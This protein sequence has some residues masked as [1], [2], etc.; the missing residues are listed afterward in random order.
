MVLKL[1]SKAL[2]LF[3]IISVL[4]ILLSFTSG[5]IMNDTNT[6]LFVYCEDGLY[7][8]SLS[9]EGEPQKEKILSSE[10][11][12][13]GEKYDALFVL[14]I[15]NAPYFFFPKK[16]NPTFTSE[17]NCLSIS[18]DGKK[19]IGSICDP[20]YCS[21]SYTWIEEIGSNKK[22]FLDFIFDESFIER[23]YNLYSVLA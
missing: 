17:L 16:I 10:I 4:N 15:W 8:L 6:Q 18:N 11:E 13:K 5:C 23:G 12:Y 14:R 20:D 9:L 7:R 1:K 3:S 19:I 2:K 22:F 21:P